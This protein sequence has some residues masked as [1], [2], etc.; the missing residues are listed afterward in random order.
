MRPSA[1][2][3]KRIAAPSHRTQHSHHTSLRSPYPSA[4]I[5]AT[6]NAHPRWQVKHAVA[7]HVISQL[8]ARRPVEAV[9]RG[10]TE[11]RTDDFLIR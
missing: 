4:P 8:G 9:R 10:A 2:A 1:S 6:P 7:D 11:R 5:Q 3:T